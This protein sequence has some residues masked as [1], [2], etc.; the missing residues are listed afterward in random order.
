MATVPEE[1]TRFLQ[2]LREK[3]TQPDA[4]RVA[5]I[6]ASNL[7]ALIPTTTAAGQRA[8]VLT[9]L[10]RAN[11]DLTSADIDGNAAPANAQPINWTRLDSLSIGPFRGF[12]HNISIPIQS[13][14]S[15]IY[16]PNGSGKTSVCE[17]VEYALLGSVQEATAKR[18]D[19]LD[20]YF[21][22]IHAGRFEPP[23][24]R[25]QVAGGSALIAQD[26]DLYRFCF[27]ERNRI[28]N[29][30]RIAART[31]AQADALIATLFGL[32]A[33]RSFVNNFT[34]T[35]ETQLNL[36]TPVKR[37]FE[38][39]REKLTAA[40]TTLKSEQD[41]L[42]ELSSNMEALAS[43]YQPGLTFVELVALL[44]SDERPARLHELNLEIATQLPPMSGAQ[45]SRIWQLRRE[46]KVKQGEVVEGSAR[47]ASRATQVSFRELFAAL[48]PLADLSPDACPACNTPLAQATLNPYQRAREALTELEDVAALQEQLAGAKRERLTLYRALRD[49]IAKCSTHDAGAQP[50]VTRL[51]ATIAALEGQQEP[52]ANEMLSGEWRSALRAIRKLE[53]RDAT[54]RSALARRDDLITERNKLQAIGRRADTLVAQSGMLA[55][56][57]EAARLRVA[58]FGPEDQRL[59]AA[60]AEEATRVSLDRRIATS[61]A[62]FLE[63]LRAYLDE[64]PEV[65]LAGLNETA[66]ELY[67][68][69]NEG[70]HDSDKLAALT[71][72]MRGG[73]RITVQ[74]NGTPGQSRDAL[75]LLSEGHIRCLGLAILL[76][77]NIERNLPLIVFDDAVNAIDHDH[78]AG[79]RQTLLSDTRLA[80]KQLLITCHS[81]EFIKDFQNHAG[82]GATELHVI[83]H[84]GG[85]HQPRV[86]NGTTRHYLE[87]ANAYLDELNLRATLTYCRQAL[88]NLCWRAW[89]KLEKA[90]N[91][92]LT[93]TL[94]GWDQIP[95]SRELAQQ[96]RARALELEATDK[97]HAERWKGLRESLDLLLGIDPKN[98]VWTYLNK[99][100]HDEL[101]QDDFEEAAVRAAYAALACTRH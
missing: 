24:L 7:E 66:R 44:G 17:A 57:A 89:K 9:P 3:D 62:R 21:T 15:L 78:R 81:H 70:D 63:H 73:E 94:R 38:E 82:E 8:K 19:N 10:I 37:Q 42:T 53:R 30:A 97:K 92:E 54:T 1:Y 41:S 20:E 12:Q 6:V 51:N 31:P 43:E 68:R 11:L 56:Q 48:V 91:S 29:F 71:L 46:L 27:I 58:G 47:V 98:R 23:L 101:D 96:I 87:C 74:F 65:L 35:L 45:L 72:P 85:T 61:Y 25:A 93:L 33:F 84:H 22:N 36:D 67:N 99:G 26:A 32:D 40:E 34:N 83:R 80:T 39:L 60:A 52:P 100:T 88:E 64:L 75:G 13:R 59:T 18:I 4:C 90:R 28:E 77:K 50:A 16:G 55:S 2:W 14:I 76:A 49:E 79:I 95:Q 69:F 86:L 5:K